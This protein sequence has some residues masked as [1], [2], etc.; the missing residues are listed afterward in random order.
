MSR[1]VEEAEQRITKR[2]REL[3]LERGLTLEK[4]AAAADITPGYLSRVESGQRVPSVGT[5]VVLARVLD[6]S[7]A[8][9]ASEGERGSPIVKRDEATTY[10]TRG[11]ELMHLSPP[12][13]NAFI[14]ATRVTLRGRAIP[15]RP[16]RHGGEEWLHVV[17]GRLELVLGGEAHTL[18]KGDS[19]QFSGGTEHTLRGAPDAEVIVV[20]ASPRTGPIQ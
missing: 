20:I 7:V 9:L 13:T 18:E 15:P 6:V 16:S 10:G 8:D 14:E 11:A 1:E 3:R 2:L 12:S 17:S 5:L 19:A 4:V